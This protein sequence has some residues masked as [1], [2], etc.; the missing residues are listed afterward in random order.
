[1][2]Q[3]P[4]VL[5][6][7]T[8]PLW[9]KLYEHFQ[10]KITITTTPDE[11]AD[12]HWMK[13]DVEIAIDNMEDL[14]EIVDTYFFPQETKTEDWEKVREIEKN[15]PIG[16]MEIYRY[17]AQNL[18]YY[19]NEVA[20]LE[21]LE[22]TDGESENLGRVP[23]YFAPEKIRKLHY[24]S[25]SISILPEEDFVSH[26]IDRRGRIKAK[27]AYPANEYIDMHN[28]DW[29][30]HVN[31][32]FINKEF[33]GYDF[34]VKAIAKFARLFCKDNDVVSAIPHPIEKDSPKG[35]SVGREIELLRTYWCRAGF[36]T[37]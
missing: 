16:S 4:L 6:P 5:S 34:G 26:E 28:T 8:L 10:L 22:Y 17:N 23:L 19:D 25:L 35:R 15:S 9:I 24:G 1:M 20:A 33:R 7:K 2:I 29:I 37:Y 11:T 31:S 18:T 12:S 21:L 27:E 30:W 13:Y 3:H 32:I 14:L 36:D